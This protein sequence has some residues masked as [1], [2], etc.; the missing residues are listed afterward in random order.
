MTTSRIFQIFTR[1][2]VQL[3]LLAIACIIWGSSYATREPYFSEAPLH[4]Y[5]PHVYYYMFVAL[6]FESFLYKLAEK[7]LLWKWPQRFHV[8]I[9]FCFALLMWF[10]ERIN[11]DPLAP[12]APFTH[13]ALC[14]AQFLMLAG[15]LAFFTLLTTAMVRGLQKERRG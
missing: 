13:V 8:A 2:Q 6:L 9:W 3:F 10:I 4:L 11:E 7:N 5:W 12:R 14:I 15:H 1:P